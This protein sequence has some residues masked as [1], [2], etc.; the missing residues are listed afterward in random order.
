MHTCL[1]QVSE[2]V[3]AIFLVN[4]GAGIFKDLAFSIELLHVLQ[5]VAKDNL[6]LMREVVVV[7]IQLDD[8]QGKNTVNRVNDQVVD[9][10][11]NRNE[12]TFHRRPSDV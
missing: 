3:V 8:R 12:L 6:E 11:L 5:D 9:F 1:E 4:R 10:A 7:S 2:E